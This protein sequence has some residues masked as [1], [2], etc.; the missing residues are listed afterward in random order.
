MKNAASGYRVA[1]FGAFRADLRAGELVRNGRRV[2]LQEQPFQILTILLERRG[3]LVTREELRL[4]LW[5]ADTF[6]DFD[7]GLNNAINRLR[8]ALG[9]SA[10]SARYIETLSRRGYRFIAPVSYGAS[11]TG[12]AAGIERSASLAAPEDVMAGRA[13]TLSGRDAFSWFGASVATFVVLLVLLVGL[14]RWRGGRVKESRA[15]PIRS[16]AVLPLENLT[17]DSSQDYFADGMTEALITNLE[18][19]GALTVI[20]RTSAMHYKATRKTL[21][22]I[23]REL[24]VDAI[25]E[26][27]VLR[28]G[29]RVRITA[30]LIR[31]EPE[32]HLWTQT[33]ERDVSDV[34]ALQDDIARAV[35]NDIQVKLTPQEQGRLVRARLVNPE[36]Y[37]A[38]L[39][40][41]FFWNKFTAEGW[42]KGI[43]YFGES[44]RLDRSYAPAYAGLADCY[45]S[46]GAFGIIRP[47]ETTPKGI[48]AVQKS[49]QLDETSAEAHFSLANA[50]ITY[51][52]DWSGAE[53]E[54]RRGFE[55]NP[56]YALGHNYYSLYLSAMGRFQTAIWEQERAR[57]L[58]PLSLIINTNLSRTL[59]Y[60]RQYDRAIEEGLKTV[61]LDANFPLVHGWLMEA[62][63]RKG[64]Y[65]EAV[66]ERQKLVRDSSEAATLEAVF[67]VSGYNGILRRDVSSMIDSSK[68]N[69]LPAD[70]LA[71]IFAELNDKEEAM[72]WLEK[73]YEE[74]DS[75][76]AL[77]NI[78]PEYD[79]LR[80]APRFQALLV[81]VGFSR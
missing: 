31:A 24:K 25:V 55:L 18:Q 49:L 79:K 65:K 73:A 26:G 71:S 28:S 58:D 78:A 16:L 15:I 3:E 4:K 33:Y 64:M 5:P 67:K 51:E 52:W 35:A 7:H 74:R 81:K 36:A 62:Y 17:G 50:K 63:A 42:Q 34:M 10:E 69:Y 12:E 2:R 39:K 6:V 57:D 75:G 32:T 9:D 60:A 45:V 68:R 20:S 54:F 43:D 22:E 80:S 56:S 61:E 44:I 1:E 66:R 72:R 59:Y 14:V 29:K 19:T 46:L 38:Y 8:E 13:E 23:A 27:T 48:A 76:V 47:R 37:D 53:R 70:V 30:K 11:A 77:L 21:P 41:R 40:G